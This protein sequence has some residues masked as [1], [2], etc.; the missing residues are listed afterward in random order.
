MEGMINCSIAVLPDS[1]L[2]RSSPDSFL[3]RSSPDLSFPTFATL[4]KSNDTGSVKSVRSG[5]RST[6][7]PGS[8]D[9]TRVP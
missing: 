7:L 4:A 9:Y 1:F 6:R 8:V 2:H 5:D 3:H